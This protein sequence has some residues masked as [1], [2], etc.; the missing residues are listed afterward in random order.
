MVKIITL[1]KTN[2]TAAVAAAAGVGVQIRQNVEN[3]IITWW[4]KKI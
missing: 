3:K 2:W 1:S 4:I